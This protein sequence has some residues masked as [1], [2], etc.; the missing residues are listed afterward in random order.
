[1]KNLAEILALAK[2]QEETTFILLTLLLLQA[3]PEYMG[4]ETDIV[5]YVESLLESR[6]RRLK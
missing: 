3:N 6:F 1:M 2:R 5:H 4:K